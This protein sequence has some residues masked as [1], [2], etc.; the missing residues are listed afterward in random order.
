MEK[1]GKKQ[2]KF[3]IIS[4]KRKIIEIIQRKFENGTEIEEFQKNF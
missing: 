2:K 3:K 4:R 1:F